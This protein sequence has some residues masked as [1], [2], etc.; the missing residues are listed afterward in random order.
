MINNN[1][2]EFLTHEENDLLLSLEEY[3]INEPSLIIAKVTQYDTTNFIGVEKYVYFYLTD[4]ANIEVVMV[5]DTFKKLAKI[6]YEHFN[7]GLKNIQDT[8]QR[9]DNIVAI[10]DVAEQ[11]EYQEKNLNFFILLEKTIIRKNRKIFPL[12]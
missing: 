7:I 2:K 11:L 3:I 5:L 10:S 1:Q 6:L 8:L 12:T 9:Q 4:S